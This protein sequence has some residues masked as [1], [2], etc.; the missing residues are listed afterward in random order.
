MRQRWFIFT[1]ETLSI[2]NFIYESPRG[3]NVDDMSFT[4]SLTGNHI[5]RKTCAAHLLFPQRG[6]INKK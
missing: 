1:F 3:E 6:F 5:N 4:K 2:F